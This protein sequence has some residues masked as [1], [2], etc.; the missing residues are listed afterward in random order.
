MAKRLLKIA[1][2]FLAAA[3]CTVAAPGHAVCQSGSTKALAFEKRDYVEIEGTKNFNLS[4]A[5]TVE[6]WV[7]WSIRERDRQYLFGDEAWPGMSEK[8]PVKQESGCALRTTPLS[9]RLRA[10]ELVLGSTNGWLVVT[11]KEVPELGGWHHIA[12]SKSP[13]ML[14][15]FRDGKLDAEKTCTGVTFNSSPTNLFLGVR[16]YGWKDRSFQGGIRMFRI[17]SSARYE[18]SFK[19]QRTFTQA[20]ATGVPFVFSDVRGVRSPEVSANIPKAP[21]FGPRGLNLGRSVNA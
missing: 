4:A 15:L 10:V 17:S 16:Q 3:L 5:F 20:A 13:Q 11:G 8:I 21:S 18:T 7:T 2:A 6:M 14:R 12:V 1:G 19:P 9:H